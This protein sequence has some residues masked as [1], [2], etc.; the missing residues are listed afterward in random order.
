M[1]TKIDSPP[2]RD[3]GQETRDTLEAQIDLAPELFAA[4]A[5]Y[6]PK[7]AQLNLEKL[8]TTLRGDGVSPG[9]LA[10]YEEEIAPTLSRVSSADR[11]SRIAGELGALETYAP[12]VT[13]ALR[14]ASGSAPLLDLLNAQAQEELAAGADLDPSLEREISQ[15]VRAGQAARGMGWGQPDVVTEAYSRGARGEELRRGRRNFAANVVGLNQAVSGDPLMAI[16]GRP[17]QTAAMTPGVAGQ[18]AGM[19]PG[20]IFSPE[21]GYASDV[22]NTNFNADA[23]ARIASGN[24]TA[25]LFGAGIGAIGKLGGSV[26]GA[27]W[28]N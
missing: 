17:S 20:N 4:E 18:A 22:Y 1:S 21:S 10:L 26:I 24:A 16:L 25:G 2:P 5:E 19:S 23:A 8:G 7:Y 9:L 27:P 14:E 15:G 13:S 3:Y 6:G 28:W 12:R 11:D